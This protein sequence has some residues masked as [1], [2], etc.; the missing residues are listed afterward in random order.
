MAAVV[1]K[2]LVVTW[3]TGYNGI[4]VTSGATTLRPLTEG[5][6]KVLHF[7]FLSLMR[8]EPDPFGGREFTNRI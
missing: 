4:N 7:F 5:P 2:T 6:T 8:H 3:E 1:S